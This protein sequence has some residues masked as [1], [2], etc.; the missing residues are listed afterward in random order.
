MDALADA[1]HPPQLSPRAAGN[2][3]WLLFLVA[4]FRLSLATLPIVALLL[5]V[6]YALW[7]DVEGGGSTHFSFEPGVVY[8]FLG[9]TIFVLSILLGGVSVGAGAGWV[10]GL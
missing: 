9:T 10:G 2:Q 6:R 3:G 7:K 4:R 5:G 8:T 1:P